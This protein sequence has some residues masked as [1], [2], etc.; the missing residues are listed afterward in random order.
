MQWLI[1][2]I[3]LTFVTQQAMPVVSGLIDTVDRVIEHVVTNLEPSP[4]SLL[5]LGGTSLVAGQRSVSSS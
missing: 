5:S 1:R 4:K 3:I 2:L